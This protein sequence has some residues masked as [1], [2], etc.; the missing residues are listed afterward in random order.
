MRQTP[1]RAFALDL[2]HSVGF[3]RLEHGH[4]PRAVSDSYPTVA[5]DRRAVRLTE[6]AVK[7]VWGVAA[8]PADS[9]LLIG[10][11]A[12]HDVSIYNNK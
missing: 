11:I 3:L 8:T 12:M 2:S 5:L 6:L 10:L 9:G 7:E 4:D 1:S